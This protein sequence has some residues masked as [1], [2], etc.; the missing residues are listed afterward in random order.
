VTTIGCE[1][2]IIHSISA[3]YDAESQTVTITCN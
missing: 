1:G 3:S 2:P